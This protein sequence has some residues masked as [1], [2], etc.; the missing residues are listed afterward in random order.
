M[1]L[2][3]PDTVRRALTAW[4]R[5]QREVHAHVRSVPTENLHLTL[6][7]LGT[8]S[9]A[10]IDAIA[11]AVA[12]VGRDGSAM[13]LRTGPPVWLPP[14]RP[15]ALAV[16]V[17]DDRG[18][19]AMLHRS[20][21]GVLADAIGWREAHPLRPHVTV[22]RRTSSEPMP[23]RGLSATPALNFAG[24]ALTLYRST[25]DPD[26]ARYAAVERVALV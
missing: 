6:A 7:F 11:D 15:R 16:E 23:R 14:R 26:G 9:P 12:A 24:E 13:G 18:D 21:V 5:T 1:A 10:E 8:R 22:G 25:L 20:L 17:H 19:L 2:D 4:L 3:P